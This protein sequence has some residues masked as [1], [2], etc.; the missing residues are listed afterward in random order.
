MAS[1]GNNSRQQTSTSSR[2][3]ARSRANANANASARRGSSFGNSNSIARAR[4]IERARENARAAYAL[5]SAI[6]Y[7][8]QNAIN[9]INPTPNNVSRAMISIQ[10]RSQRGHSNFGFIQPRTYVRPSPQTIEPRV[11]TTSSRQLNHHKVPRNR[12]R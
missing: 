10:N 5:E 4:A 7:Q 2:A 11:A 9:N 6:V 3:S 8:N 12:I 1:R